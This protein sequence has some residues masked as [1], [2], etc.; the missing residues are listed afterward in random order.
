MN[1]P[2]AETMLA[3]FPRLAALEPEA[4][5]LLAQ[6]GEAIAAPTGTVLFR[7]GEICTRFV[8]LRRG[9]VRVQMLSDTGHEIVLYRVRSG[10]TC[11]LTTSCLIAHEAYSAEGVAEGDV[12]AL[13]LAVADFERLMGLSAVFRGFV[14]AAFGERIAELM[15]RLDEVAFRSIDAR[16]AR[17]L[18]D[19]AAQGG[20]IETTHHALA[21][22]LGTAREVVSRRLKHLERRGLVALARGT[23]ELR[24]RAGLRQLA[25]E[26]DS[27]EGG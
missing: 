19:A 13:L 25:A 16:L 6:S 12:E 26:S 18:L 9:T 24:D 15:H 5:A 3:S 21:V 4:R 7:P 11:V 27:P 1:A 22:E 2:S 10:E 14:L 23:I 17:R 8:M 20:G